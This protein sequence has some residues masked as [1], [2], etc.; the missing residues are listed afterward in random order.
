MARTV[1]LQQVVRADLLC[2]NDVLLIT[3][4]TSLDW[5]IDLLAGFR[6]RREAAPRGAD[7]IRIL[8]GVEPLASA[9]SESFSIA[10]WVCTLTPTPRAL[11][12]GQGGPYTV[13][14]SRV[15]DFTGIYLP[16]GANPL[17]S[18]SG[19]AIADFNNDGLDDVIYSGPIFP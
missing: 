17:G 1:F 5:V 13:D 8:I 9:T 18:A 16:N 2:S 7:R 3:G 6:A 12:T 14:E 15:P 11:P 10:Q 4:Y 19:F